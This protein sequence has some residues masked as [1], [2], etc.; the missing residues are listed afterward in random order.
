[1][2]VAN[3]ND[4][5]TRAAGMFSRSGRRQEPT[6]IGELITLTEGR[7]RWHKSRWHN[8]HP[9]EFACP[10]CGE[11]CWQPGEYDK[12]QRLRDLINKPVQFNSVH[13]CRR[14]NA[15]VGGAPKSQHKLNAF[16]FSMRRYLAGDGVKVS[17]LQAKMIEAGFRTF[18]LYGTF[19]H[20]DSRPGRFWIVGGGKRWADNFSRYQRGN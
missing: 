10:C 11:M 18:G 3:A 13:R 16:D 8:F 7:R 6:P 4:F 19:I 1:M 20:L 5:P 2:K 17:G 15:K 9:A 14:H 12:A